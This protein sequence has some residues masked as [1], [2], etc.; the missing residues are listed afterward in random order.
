V[1]NA[2]VR[3]RDVAMC[4]VIGIPDERWGERVH[5]V[6]VRHAA[7]IVSEAELIAHCKTLIAG[8]KCPRSIEF[9]TEL[10]IS[11]AGKLLKHVLRA[12]Y[13]TGHHRQIA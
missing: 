7:S 10:P 5:A 2:L 1:E 13:W 3:H 4:A 6:V 9:R 11:A 12:P 8:Y